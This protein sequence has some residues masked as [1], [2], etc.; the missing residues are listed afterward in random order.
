MIKIEEDKSK[1]LCGHVWTQNVSI[2][3]AT[4]MTKH[5]PLL[6]NMIGY[7]FITNCS[8]SFCQFF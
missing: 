6:A 4:E 2:I 5:S 8:F 1:A 7:C 3:Q